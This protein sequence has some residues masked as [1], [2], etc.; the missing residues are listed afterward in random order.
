MMDP[1]E[2]EKHYASQVDHGGEAPLGVAV[3]VT[4]CVARSRDG[5]PPA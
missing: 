3:N 1:M 4:E 2:S 5:S